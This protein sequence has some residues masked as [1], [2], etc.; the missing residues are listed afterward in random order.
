MANAVKT[1]FL[2][3]THRI[4][5]LSKALSGKIGN[6]TILTGSFPYPGLFSGVNKLY[7]PGNP[8]IFIAS[9]VGRIF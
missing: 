2:S 1:V 9:M 3:K 6:S 8:S 4:Q 5:Y 7:P